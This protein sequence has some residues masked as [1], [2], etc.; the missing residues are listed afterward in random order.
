MPGKK[1]RKRRKIFFVPNLIVKR[2]RGNSGSGEGNLS[3]IGGDL[4]LRSVSGF[5]LGGEAIW[6]CVGI[7]KKASFVF[8]SF[9]AHFP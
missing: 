8:C 9:L 4:F 5:F 1:D 6:V 7:R 3:I 2:F